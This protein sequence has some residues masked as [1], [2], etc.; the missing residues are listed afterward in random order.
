MW[1]DSY[2]TPLNINRV[3]SNTTES[4]Y[5]TILFTCDSKHRVPFNSFFHG[6]RLEF[7]FYWSSIINYAETTVFLQKKR[8]LISL[9]RVM[10][11]RKKLDRICL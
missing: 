11:L 1:R 4:I 5:C 6:R 3:A 7:I 9:Y 10:F 8:Q 2:Q